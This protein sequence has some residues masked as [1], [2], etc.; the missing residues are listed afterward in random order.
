MNYIKRWRRILDLMVWR[1]SHHVC[2]IER[3]FMM[4]HEGDHRCKCGKMWAPMSTDN[5]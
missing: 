3:Q 1:H 2:I 4:V 5:D